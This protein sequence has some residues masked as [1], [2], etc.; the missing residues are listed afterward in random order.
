MLTLVVVCTLPR[1]GVPEAL[2]GRD[3]QDVPLYSTT[4]KSDIPF[5]VIAPLISLCESHAMFTRAV[6][7]VVDETPQYSAAL[8]STI[9]AVTDADV[10][11]GVKYCAVN[12]AEPAEVEVKMNV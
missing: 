3:T 8:T 4:L 7:V 10:G 9:G 5:C 1:V 2:D 11:L 6:L 12:S